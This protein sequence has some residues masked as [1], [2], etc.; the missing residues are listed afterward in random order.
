VIQ[1]IVDRREFLGVDGI[2]G[3]LGLERRDFAL[4]AVFDRVAAPGTIDGETD[5]T[6]AAHQEAR[7]LGKGVVVA[8]SHV[9]IGLAQKAWWRGARL[10]SPERM[11]P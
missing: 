10:S 8:C 6:R 2:L 7:P 4:A 5:I 3:N 1:G 11:F 9:E